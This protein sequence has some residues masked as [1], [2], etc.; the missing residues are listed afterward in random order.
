MPDTTVRVHYLELTRPPAPVPA[1][2]GSERIAA[3]RLALESYLELYQQV[4]AP[5][6]WDQRL[7][8]PRAQLAA[9][10]A[11]A[12]LRIYVLRQASGTPLGF[13]EL[14]RSAFPD[15]ELKNFGLIP[16]AQGRGLGPWLLATALQEEWRLQP[17]RIWL[18]TDEWDHP[19]ALP[20]YQRA[21]FELYLT[22]T[23][24]S[25]PL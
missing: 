22:R 24:A 9:L 5:L 23:E 21:G 7:N 4:G 12:A 15:I 1:H 10:L 17:R 13:C 3:E 6:R 14:D 25:G 18:H 19:A 16:Q 11:G 2:S 8:M 20:L